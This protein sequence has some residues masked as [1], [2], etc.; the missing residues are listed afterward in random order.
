MAS[1]IKLSRKSNDKQK[2]ISRLTRKTSNTNKNIID[3][4]RK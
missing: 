4:N 3:D 1:R 2:I